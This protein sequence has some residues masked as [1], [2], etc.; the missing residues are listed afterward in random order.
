LDNDI[1]IIECLEGFY[2]DNTDSDPNKWRC[3]ECEIE[4]C[5]V[6]SDMWTCD[7]CEGDWFPEADM[8]ACIEPIECI[9]PPNL[10]PERL[11]E[12][13]GKWVCT[14]CDYGQYFCLDTCVE[15]NMCYP[16]SDAHSECKSCGIVDE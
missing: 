12:I 6:C 9:V 10:Q 2:W 14:E 15:S 5:T 3:V 16:C 4:H 7:E 11:E 8:S 13:D 1:W